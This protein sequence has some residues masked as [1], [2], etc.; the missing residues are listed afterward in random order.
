M[1]NKKNRNNNKK[2]RRELEVLRAQLKVQ[3]ENKTEIKIEKNI[4]K[5]QN[6]DPQLIVD[7]K[8]IKKDI[9]KTL[10]LSTIAFT[11]IASLWFIK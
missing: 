11:V 3:P 8:A 1:A 2:L 9:L 10:A 6:Y 7:D 5:Q 4:T